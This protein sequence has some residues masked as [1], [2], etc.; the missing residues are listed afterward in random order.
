MKTAPLPPNEA[1]RM[2]L[3]RHL[4]IM[5]TAPETMFDDITRSVALI[6]DAPIVLICLVDEYRQW[7]KSKVGLDARETSRDA[8]F[9][10]HAILEDE[11]LLVPD[12]LK[13]ERF[14]DNPL[15]TGE[16]KVR[17]YAGA[18]LKL[19]PTIRLGTLCVIDHKPRV[20]DR[21]QLALLELLSSHVTS[22][23]RLRLHKIDASRD[24]SDMVM[25]KQKLQYQKDLFEA[26]LDNEPECVVILARDGT[27]EQ[28][29]LAGLDMLEIGSL[30]EARCRKLSDFVLPEFRDK[31]SE[32]EHKVFQGAHAIAEYKIKGAKGTERWMESHAAPLYNQQG[33]IANL[34]AVTRDITAIKQS[35]RELTLAARVFGEAQEGIIITDANGTIVNINPAFC[36]ITGY[37][38]EEIIGQNPRILQSGKQSPDFYTELWQT[39]G[40]TGHWQGEIWNRK[41]NGELYAEL[42][43]INALRDENGKAINYIALFLDIT[44]V[45]RQRE[46]QEQAAHYDPVTGLPKHAIFTDR[47]QQALA[48]SRRDRTMLAVCHLDLDNFRQL[49]HT[50]GHETCD[51]LLTATAKRIKTNLRGKDTASSLGGDEF[52]LLIGD[53]RDLSDC[54]RALER[55][56]RT[57]AESH[58]INGQDAS[59][60]VSSG[61][62]LFPAHGIDQPSLLRH[63]EQAMRLAKRDGYN[64]YHFY[65]A[66]DDS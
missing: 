14:I 45:K 16:P 37:N 34:I 57:I 24:F 25:V 53:I 8:A 2:R 3:L 55:I 48:S 10:A 51:A 11:I 41:K 26:I 9:C 40:E 66:T 12:A 29:N 1:E 20:L 52:V 36:A 33:E 56:H 49:N 15:V 63:A 5:D 39:V 30:A 31:F 22:L 61:V 42:I 38:S 28:I 54:E 35:Q 19:T 18:P 17:F 27:L 4:E 62:A 58:Y 44:E 47:F 13:D 21:K 50:L 23:I 43:S 46:Y 6:C 60:T 7:F 59:L 65:N 32:L 64:R